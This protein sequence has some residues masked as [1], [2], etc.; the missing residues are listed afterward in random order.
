[1]S[2]MPFAL[3]KPAHTAPHCTCFAYLTNSFGLLLQAIEPAYV[4][5]CTHAN[6]CSL[7]CSH[8]NSA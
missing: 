2:D 5:S 6:C 3:V 1:M 8:A 7:I 4:A